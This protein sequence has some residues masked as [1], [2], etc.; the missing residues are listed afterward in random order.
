MKVSNLFFSAAIS[1]T[2]LLALPNNLY[3]DVYCNSFGTC[4]GTNSAGE[5]VN[6]HTNSFGTT[7]GT[8]GGRSVNVHTNSFGTTSGSIGGNSVNC[9]TNS[10]GTTSCY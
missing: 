1:A 2:G 5:S 3:A 10:F 8:I 9:H 7:S 6:T 4:T